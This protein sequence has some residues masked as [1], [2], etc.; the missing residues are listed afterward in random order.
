MRRR[1]RFILTLLAAAFCC[2]VAARA[3]TPPNGTVIPTVCVT[4]NNRSGTTTL[5]T[6]AAAGDGTINLD[7]QGGTLPLNIRVVINPGGANEESFVWA[8]KSPAYV[9]RTA[10]GGFAPLANAHNAGETVQW[11]TDSTVVWGYNNTGSSTVTIPK[12][13]QSP[14][15]FLPGPLSYAGQPNMFLP[16]IH[17]AFSL[18][19]PTRD[20]LAINWFLNGGQATASK[21]APACAQITYQGRL[22]TGGAQASGGYDMQFTVYDALAGGTAQSEMLTVANVQVT[23]GVFT[24]PLNFGSSF[25]NNG[26][27]RYLE[28]GVRQAGATSAF[29]ILAPR[30]P[31]TDAPFAVNAQTAQKA[32]DVQM[33]LTTGAPSSTDCSAATQYGQTRV[34][35]T[36]NKLYICTSTG[37]KS[38][39][40]Q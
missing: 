19:L 20:G 35:A 16:G 22:T 25:Y 29:T 12:S 26:S 17:T 10:T 14:N 15:Y 8:F 13:T 28:I 36:N 24:V 11:F 32:F 37:W 30:Q 21:N 4:P 2:A 9:L 38:T 39:T 27:A 33:I 40:L 6:N 1:L 23:N 31:I 7:T 34:D 18:D 3:Q 5:S